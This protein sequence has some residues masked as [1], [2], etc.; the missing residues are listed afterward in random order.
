M[1]KVDLKGIAKVRA[2]GRIYYYAW[3]GGP[4]LKG[5]PGSPEFM[6]S[7]HEAVE[8]R[9]AP[10]QSHFR[11]VV[12]D[13]KASAGYKKLAQSTREQ[14]GKWLDRIGNYFGELRIAQF[15]RPE[16]I[17]PV[18]RRWRDQWADTPRTADYA[19]QVLSR[20]AAHAVEIGRIAGNPC[21]GIKHLYNNDRSE[22]IWTDSDIAHIKRTCSAE[23]ANAI[24]LAAHTGLRLSDLVRVAWS[25][26]GDEAIVLTT[27]KSRH[28]REAIIPLYGALR[29]ILARIPKRATT[30]L[31]NSRS[32]PWTS[33]GLGSSFNKAKM[34]ADMF[35]RDL[36]FNDLRGTAATKFYIA[37]FTEREIAETLAWEEESVRKIIRR[38][39]GRTAAIK[40]RIKKLEAKR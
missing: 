20:V 28:R 9:R 33:D 13:Y 10:D 1:L 24:D 11:F 6:A 35:E 4:R 27:G 5:K 14:W 2:K 34:D 40:A 37:E 15:D 18:I 23:I 12:S 26:I 22:I 25:H 38:Y 29:D 3:R 30:I 21:E 39:V 31:T 32:R 17:R 7:Y 16:K 36:H 19:L 8:S